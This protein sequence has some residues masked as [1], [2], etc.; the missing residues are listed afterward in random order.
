MKP[1]LSQYLPRYRHLAGMP[2][3]HLRHLGRVDSVD[4]WE[5]A[6][7]VIRDLKDI[8][9]T[10]SAYDLNKSYIPKGEVWV[11]RDAA[12]TG[13]QKTWLY[14][15]LAER[16]CR[17]RLGMSADAAFN[18]AKRAEEAL[19][20]KP[21]APPPRVQL[22]RLN[23]IKGFT[24]WL[25]NGKLVRDHYYVDFT[26]GGNG[27]VYDWAPKNEIWIDNA[28]VPEE[29]MPTTIHELTEAVWMRDRG[30]SYEQAHEHANV[31]EIT[32]RR[33]TPW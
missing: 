4:I 3:V 6:G 17:T 1:D 15:A 9:F 23:V 16:N 7:K 5:V 12:K 14:R 22:V 30:L 21:L 31:A 32:Y 20:G 11:D 26:Q 28:L 19:R 29:Y 24:V 27:F 2:D 33:T 18:E 13:E 8:E 25:V 10:Q